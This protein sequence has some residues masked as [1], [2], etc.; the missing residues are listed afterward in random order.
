MSLLLNAEQQMLREAAAAFLAERSPV[1][2][3]RRWRGSE[4]GERFDA[5]LWREV[6]DL[7][8]TA[9][10]WPEQLGGLEA[11][12]KG[13]GAVFE[14]MG[15]HLCALPLLSSVVLGGSL[16]VGGGSVALREQWLPRVMDGTAR[17]ALGLDERARHAPGE[18]GTQVRRDGQ[19]WRLDG[20]K[21]D[22]LDGCGAEGYVVAAR[23]EGQLHLFL[24]PS[25][26][27]GLTVTPLHRID[28]RNAAAISLEA[29]CVDDTAL[30]GSGSDAQA[31]LDQALDRARLCLAAETLGLTRQAFEMTLRYL[32]ER[33]QFD[34]PIGSFQALQHRAARLLVG[35]ELLDSCVA[36][37]LDA[38]DHRPDEVPLLASL[39][40]ARAAELGELLLNEAVQ[41]HGGIGVTD[42]FDLGL[43][44]KR[45]RSISQS[46]GDA[47]FHRDRYARLKGF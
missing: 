42:E 9:A 37:G 34:V 44:L 36:A 20:S 14:Q 3:Q 33:V 24:V 21:R 13:L 12:W 40:K 23:C 18:I 11:G 19:G 27:P 28:S 22:V 31:A 25:G 16:L 4:A 45:A 41:M 1:S 8:W 10:P 43:F 39:A 2:A 30:L 47:L 29:V 17:L 26:V 46:L 35:L 5:G 32:K 7:G 6:V 38:L 15:R